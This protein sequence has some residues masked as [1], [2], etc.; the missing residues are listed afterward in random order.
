[1]PFGT[2]FLLERVYNFTM[3]AYKTHLEAVRTSHHSGVTK[4][5]IQVG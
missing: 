1:M 3:R 5:L 4:N 2:P